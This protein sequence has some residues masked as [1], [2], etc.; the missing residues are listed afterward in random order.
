MSDRN[1]EIIRGGFK[2]FNRGD[3]DAVVETLDDEVMV[4]ISWPHAQQEEGLWSETRPAAPLPGGRVLV[5]GG[6]GASFA[7][8]SAELF[9]PC[10]KGL[11]LKKVKGKRKCVKEKKRP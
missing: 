2:G 8:R 7:L 10:K 1:V 4:R 11:K 6:S 3:L 5:A 9:S